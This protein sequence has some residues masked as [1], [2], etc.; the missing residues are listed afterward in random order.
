PTTADRQPTSANVLTDRMT[1][2]SVV[3]PEGKHISGNLKALDRLVV[4]IITTLAR[5][6][7]STAGLLIGRRRDGAHD[8]ALP[9]ADVAEAVRQAA[10]E[11]I[12][13]A[14]VQHAALAAHRELGSPARHHAGL[15]G[16]VGEGLARIRP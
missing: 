4:T 2:P 6:V 1:F 9:I 3:I 10:V 16:G 12:A 8:L 14:L 13:V 11:I 15:L 5:R 7:N